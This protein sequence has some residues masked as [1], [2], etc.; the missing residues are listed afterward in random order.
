M[1]TPMAKNG[2]SNIYT[3]HAPLTT[4][5]TIQKLPIQ[6]IFFTSNFLG[7]GYYLRAVVNGARTVD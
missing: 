2:M 6:K 3:V 1:K 5:V 4:A 7:S